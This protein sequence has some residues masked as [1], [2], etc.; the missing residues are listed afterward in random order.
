[1][2]DEILNSRGKPG[3]L[4]EKIAGESGKVRDSGLNSSKLDLF[5]PLSK[6]FGI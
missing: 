2:G 6:D 5:S 1:M 4:I 3:I